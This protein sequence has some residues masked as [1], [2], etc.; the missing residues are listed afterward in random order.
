[1]AVLA[2]LVIIFTVTLDGKFIYRALPEMGWLRWTGLAVLDLG[3]LGWAFAFV[4]GA[5]GTY[6]KFISA[7]MVAFDFLGVAIISGAE[8]LTGGQQLY[9]VDVQS[10]QAWGIR[11]LI[12]WVIVNA[13]VLIV[14]EL[15]SPNIAAEIKDGIRIDK[16]MELASKK[17]DEKMN[18][19]ADVVAD[20]K[21]ERTLNV[22]LSKL[23]A[24]EEKEVYRTRKKKVPPVSKSEIVNYNQD[25]EQL[26]ISDS[27]NGHKG[28]EK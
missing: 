5:R 17:L 2:L 26:E 8:I 13:A 12:A 23:G 28:K 24:T 25:V 21:A 19:I 11:G 1:M 15:C 18:D 3:V 14:Y 10:I 4:K 9:E 22:A 6:Q 16:I 7:S 20:E 27:K